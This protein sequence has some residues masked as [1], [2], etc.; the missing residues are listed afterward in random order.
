MTL[1]DAGPLVAILDRRDID[2]ARC[3][4]ALALIADGKMVTTWPCLTEAMYLLGREGGLR[5]QEELWKYVA[6]GILKLHTPS[7][8]EW[9]RMR[10]LM[11]RYGDTP[12]DLADASI[13]SAAERLEVRRVF[14]VD[15]HF[16]AY[17]IDGTH[18]FDVIP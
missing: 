5:V 10:S 8:G 16:R 11:N 13:V 2:H 7:P 9:Q 12:M 3:V 18:A 4:G 17:R 15:S 6:E 1:C 14:T